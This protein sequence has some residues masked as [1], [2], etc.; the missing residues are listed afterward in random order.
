MSAPCPHRVGTQI[1][2]WLM[3][4]LER[5]AWGSGLALP[6]PHLIL[7]PGLMLR[8]KGSETGSGLESTLGCMCER[9]MSRVNRPGPI[10]RSKT[11]ESS[12]WPV[13]TWL[14]FNPCSWPTSHPKAEACR[15]LR[16]TTWVGG[17]HSL[18]A[19]GIWAPDTTFKRSEG[20]E[21][22]SKR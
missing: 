22:R 5:Q 2:H 8:Y 17:P 15:D 18:S 11:A 16:V 13:R 6:V 3:E 20:T 9:L 19:P 10:S 7:L 4:K 14:F 1:H 21:R 12:K